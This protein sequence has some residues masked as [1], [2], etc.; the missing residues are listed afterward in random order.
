MISHILYLKSV[1]CSLFFCCILYTAVCIAQKPYFRNYGVEDGLP[2]SE[3]YDILQ[4]RSGFIWIATDRGVSRYDGYSFRNFSSADGLTDNTIFSLKEDYSGRIW[5]ATLNNRL[6]Y[7]ENVNHIVPYQYN[8]QLQEFT[9][10]VCIIQS[11]D[12]SEGGDVLVGR[13][14]RGCLKINRAGVRTDLRST[15][16]DSVIMS[17][18]YSCDDYFIFGSVD[19]RPQNI[20][21]I[22]PQYMVVNRSGTDAKPLWIQ[23]ESAMNYV[24]GLRKRDGTILMSTGNILMEVSPSGGTPVLHT[25]DAH[26]T[27]MTEDREGNTWIGLN[28]KGV[29]CFAPGTDLGG[30]VFNSFLTEETVTDILQ[31]TEDGYWMATL[32]HGIFFLAST[33]VHCLAPLNSSG[34]IAVSAIATDGQ[35]RVMIGTSNGWI[36]RCDENK[37]RDGIDCG[38]DTTFIHFVQDICAIPGSDQ[39][40]VCTNRSILFIESGK[41]VS[42]RTRMGFGRSICTDDS[43]GFWIGGMGG[44][45]HCNWNQEQVQKKITRGWIQHVYFDSVSRKLFVGALNGLYLWNGDSLTPYLPGEPLLSSRVTTTCRSGNYIVVGTIGN[46]VCLING[47][48]VIRIGEKEGLCSPMVNDV[49]VDNKGVIWAATNTGIA[50]IDCSSEQF[51]V[52]CYSIYHGL[53]TNEVMNVLC[54]FDT[55]WIGTASGPAW[56]VSSQMSTTAIPVP[57]YIQE[58]TV[59]GD[60]VSENAAGF[61]SYDKNHIRFSFLGISYRNSGN[62]MYRYRLTGL[63]TNWIYTTNRSVEFASLAP[64]EYRFEVMARNGDGIWSLNSVIYDFSIDNPFWYTWWFWILAVLVFGCAVSAMIYLRLRRV[65]Q[66]VRQREILA[67]YQHQALAAQMNPH[68]IFNSLSSMQAFILSDE[69]EGALRYVERF[70]FLM[71]KSLEHSILKYVSLEREIELLRAYFE[72]E[73][74]RFGDKLQYSIVCEAPLDSAAFEVPVMIVQPY[75]ENAIRHGLLH[76]EGGGQVTVTFTL[77]NNAVWCRVEDNGVGRE[78]SAEINRS[79]RKHTSFGSSITRE[80]LRLLCDVMQQEFYISYIDKKDEAGQALGTVVDFLLPSRKRK[81]NDPST[82]Y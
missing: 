12:I 2:S 21:Y 35:G 45:A 81:Q 78:R 82:A 30:N 56:F 3:T 52:S 36:Y 28:G 16:T 79:R 25:F 77:K 15:C 38:T 33:K 64:G 63:D 80:R 22:L 5:C 65:H 66:T 31:D 75:A 32:D 1:K 24:T 67:E 60:T 39:M 44:L 42:E 72:L 46:G 8:Q 19:N 68:F 18:T 54:K 34:G 7:F 62:T 76:R 69:K 10:E 50:R 29:R 48:S 47:D 61:F 6:C 26:I 58:I 27:R 14:R 40:C 71:R 49:A 70:S 4:D 43:N 11:L 9:P 59:D 41:I 13:Q 37:I 53:P 20:P 51:I 23:P 57:V 17:E 74:M 55:V 73:A